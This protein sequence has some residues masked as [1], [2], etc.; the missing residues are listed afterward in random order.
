MFRSR[1]VNHKINKLHESALMIVYNDHFSTFEELH[2]KGKSAIIYQ[3][4]IQILT[5][6]MHK[7]LNGLSQDIIQDIFE[8]KSNYYN[9]RI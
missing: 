7:I 5:P 6:E 4:N 2:S 3:R 1:Q 9:I 8:T